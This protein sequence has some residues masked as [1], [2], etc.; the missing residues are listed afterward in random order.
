MTTL[1]GIGILLTAINDD[2]YRQIAFK[3]LLELF[4]NEDAS[5]KLLKFK[6][7]SNIINY[8]GDDDEWK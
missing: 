5:V 6:V 1:E 2:K 8:Y 4:N 7:M 3:I